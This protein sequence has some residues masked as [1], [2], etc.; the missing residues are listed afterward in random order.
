MGVCSTSEARNLEMEEKNYIKIPKSEILFAIA[1]ELI[2]LIMIFT[3]LEE[4]GLVMLDSGVNILG[5]T[6]IV[7]YTKEKTEPFF[8]KIKNKY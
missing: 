5:I 1:I 6:A 8:D 7:L 3:P 2:A 4:F